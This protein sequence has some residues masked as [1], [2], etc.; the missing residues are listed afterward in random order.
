MK[1]LI[2]GIA[3]GLMLAVAMAG[4]STKQDSSG[5]A[6]VESIKI[7]F[8]NH[9]TGDIAPYGNSM[10][11]GTELA[12]EQVNKNGGVNG[13]QL[14]VVYKDD[15]SKP[16]QAV[17]ATKL[18]ID[19]KLPIVIGSSASSFTLAMRQS[20]E[21]AKVVHIAQISTNP[22][23]AG[24]G[25][26]FFSMMPGDYD[27][28]DAWMEIVKKKNIK[29]V[30]VVYI[31]NDYGN[32][33]KD[34]FTKSFTAAGGKVLTT[35]TYNE[36]ATSFQTQ[37]QKLKESTAQY[38]FIVSHIKEGALFIK[39][40]VEAGVKTQFIG[41]TALQTEDMVKQAGAAASGFMAL[42][43]GQKDHPKYK[44]FADA[45]KAKFNSEP[46]IWADF[47]YDTVLTAVEG[48]KKGGTDATKIRD[49]IAAIKDFGGATGPINFDDK[50]IRKAA[51]SFTVY[52]ILDG[53]WVQ[54]KL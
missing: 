13:K 14:E 23:L 54:A 11:N 15:Q 50:G 2:S 47:A 44:E 29:E 8:V 37:A 52:Q 28:G 17:A 49:A 1:R 26:Y 34:V 10:K 18:L 21:D 39:Q 33:V 32:G 3:A 20:L 36:S 53:K 22:K 43:V 51:N 6:K 31:N 19:Q 40:A 48:L 9:L 5:S 4:C 27:Q 24:S 30:A 16:D 12:V 25:K 42:S 41:D 35:I 45:Y 38:T 46:T 7:G